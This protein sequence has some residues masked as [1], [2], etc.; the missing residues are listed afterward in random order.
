M[1]FQSV[2]IVRAGNGAE[3]QQAFLTF[4]QQYSSE[5]PQDVSQGL[6]ANLRIIHTVI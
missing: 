5:M 2:L 6:K 4:R 1:G 3:K